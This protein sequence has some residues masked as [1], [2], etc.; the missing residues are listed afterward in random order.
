MSEEMGTSENDGKSVK[1]R[2]DER[3]GIERANERERDLKVSDPEDYADDDVIRE[4]YEE[5]SSP[6]SDHRHHRYRTPHQTSTQTQTD[7]RFSCA[8]LLF[9]FSLESIRA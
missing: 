6:D 9:W 3:G 4:T 5:N 8:Q 2:R 1:G 7:N